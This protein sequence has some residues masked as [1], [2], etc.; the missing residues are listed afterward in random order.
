MLV[1]ACYTLYKMRKNLIAGLRRAIADVKKSPAAHAATSR[2]DQDLNFKVVVFGIVAV[3]VLMVGLYYYFTGVI[4]AAI[5][6]AT[7]HARHRLLLRGRVRQ[8]GR[9]DR[10]LQQPDFRSDPG[11]PRSS[12]R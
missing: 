11:R 6:A 1:G 8:P 3:L 10:L 2:T 4:G 12:P 7:R 9:H 5:L